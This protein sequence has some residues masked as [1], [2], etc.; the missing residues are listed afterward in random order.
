MLLKLTFGL[1]FQIAITLKAVGSALCELVT[2]IY[3]YC[4]AEQ[5][6]RGPSRN[7]KNV[8]PDSVNGNRAC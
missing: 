6:N 3:R 7:P 2:S 4:I 8:M 1:Y 5:G